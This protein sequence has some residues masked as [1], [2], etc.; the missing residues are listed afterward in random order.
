MLLIDDLVASSQ[1]RSDLV[2]DH[3]ELEAG[4]GEVLLRIEI[5]DCVILQRLKISTVTKLP[6]RSVV[7]SS[8]LIDVHFMK[9]SLLLRNEH[10]GVVVVVVLDH[11]EKFV[12]SVGDR[13]G[14]PICANRQG[15]EVSIA[16]LI[17]GVIG[18]LLGLSLCDL[19]KVLL[20][21]FALMQNLLQKLLDARIFYFL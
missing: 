12:F 9:K 20:N 5:I 21:H 17:I 18:A 4:S 2:V 16:F 1:L 19:L 3:V 8:S 7:E 15:R 10:T 6:F 14:V 11:Q 13:L